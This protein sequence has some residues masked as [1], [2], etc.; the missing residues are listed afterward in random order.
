MTP[1]PIYDDIDIEVMDDSV[2]FAWT[3][4]PHDKLQF[5]NSKHRFREAY[6]AFKIL[7]I[8]ALRDT[9]IEFLLIPEFSR[10]QDSQDG[11]PSRIH[12]HGT[13]T[14]NVETHA[15]FYIE[16]FHVINKIGRM[17]ISPIKDMDVWMKYIYKEQRFIKYYIDKYNIGYE[18]TSSS[19]SPSLSV[20][21]N[22]SSKFKKFLETMRSDEDIT[23]TEF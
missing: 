1:E 20:I 9:N 4:N 11:R 23:Q 3:I 18:F 19:L 2:T 22:G 13:I 8:E 14:L 10:P 16:C 15:R 21:Q 17:N 5:K 6:S 7:M 12:Y